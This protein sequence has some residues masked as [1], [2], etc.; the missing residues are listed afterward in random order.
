MVSSAVVFAVVAMLGWGLWAVFAELATRS[1]QPEVAMIVSYLTGVVIAV[2]YVVSSGREYTFAGDGLA[3]AAVAGVFSGIGA[4]AFYTGLSEGRT[5]VVTTISA[6]YFVVAAVIG[7]ALLG[8]SLS[9]RDAAGIA[10][11]LAAVALFAG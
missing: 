8:E 6:L 10:F 11:A 7:V 9:L 2:G 1:I 4:V 5:G 3:I